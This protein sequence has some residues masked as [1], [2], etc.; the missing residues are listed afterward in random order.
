MVIIYYSTFCCDVLCFCVW[1]SGCSWLMM[2]I[3]R[4]WFGSCQCHGSAVC[5]GVG[6]HVMLLGLSCPVLCYPVLSCSVLFCA[7]L[8]FGVFLLVWLY[9][10]VL[11]CLFRNQQNN[12]TAIQTNS[13][14]MQARQQLCRESTGVE[15]SGVWRVSSSILSYLLCCS[16]LP[17]Y[18]GNWTSNLICTFVCV[19]SQVL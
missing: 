17:L 18:D 15:R 10:I 12:M 3:I 14:H 13:K 16:S 2:T 7:V 8:W 1:G 9:S 4:G 11:G 5:W 6:C 19:P